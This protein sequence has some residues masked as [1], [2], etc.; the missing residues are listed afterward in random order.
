LD[1][2][3]RTQ[4]NKP[5]KVKL[6]KRK[7]HHG[8]LIEKRP[9]RPKSLTTGYPLKS[10][11]IIRESELEGRFAVGN[12]GHYDRYRL[13]SL[14][15]DTIPRFFLFSSNNNSKEYVKRHRL[16]DKTTHGDK[17]QLFGQILGKCQEYRPHK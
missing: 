14:S 6:S 16:F 7:K 1:R 4:P 2:R 12:Y 11:A 8:K 9:S 10:S 3:F 15:R 13:N 17:I 5:S